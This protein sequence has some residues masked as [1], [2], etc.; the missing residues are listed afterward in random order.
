LF[1][2][3]ASG[4]SYVSLSL[5]PHTMQVKFRTVKFWIGGNALLSTVYSGAAFRVDAYPV[6]IEVNAGPRD[7]QT[8]I[9]GL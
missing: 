3:V 1:A 2:L 4:I 8:V 9:H 6:E 7:P 5:S